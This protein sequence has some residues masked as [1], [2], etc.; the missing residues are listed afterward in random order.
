MTKGIRGSDGRGKLLTNS[1]AL[2]PEIRK[3]NVSFLKLARK[4]LAS[5]RSDALVSLG[6]SQEMADILVAMPETEITKLANTNLLLCRFYFG[7]HVLAELIAKP[8]WEEWIALA[9]DEDRT[10]VGE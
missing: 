9:M 2:V 10:V 7:S 5:R 3:L 4:L 1:A 8:H 6:I